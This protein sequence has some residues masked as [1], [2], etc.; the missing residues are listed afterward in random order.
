MCRNDFPTQHV[1]CSALSQEDLKSLFDKAVRVALEHAHALEQ[2]KLKEKQAPWSM[3][4]R[5]NNP[6]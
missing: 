6:S 3:H 2:P 1:E 4:T 5:W